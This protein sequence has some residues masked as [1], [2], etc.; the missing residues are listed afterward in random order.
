MLEVIESYESKIKMLTD[1]EQRVQVLSR[2]HRRKFKSALL[3][4][5]RAVAAEQSREE[6][7][8][9][10]QSLENVHVDARRAHSEAIA[11]AKLASNL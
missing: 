2:Q 5:D 10:Q 4:R 7:K 11:S 8:R 9:L 3:T 1:R 6:I